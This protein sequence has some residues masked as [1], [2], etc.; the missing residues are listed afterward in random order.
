[1]TGITDDMLR[2]ICKTVDGIVAKHGLKQKGVSTFMTIDKKFKWAGNETSVGIQGTV[3]TRLLEN[4]TCP[5]QVTAHYVNLTFD[6]YENLFKI[7]VNKYPWPVARDIL[8]Y[9]ESLKSDKANRIS[10][11]TYT[12]RANTG[13]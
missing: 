13:S 1:M 12:S 2:K 10:S 9:M 8:D 3:T 11:I 6:P 4:P 7:D 5:E